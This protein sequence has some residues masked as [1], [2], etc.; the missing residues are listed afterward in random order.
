MNKMPYSIEAEESL[1]GAMLQ[2]S[3]FVIPIATSKIN[4]KDFYSERNRLLYESIIDMQNRV[5]K[6][7][8][9]NPES[10]LRYLKENGLF[11]KLFQNDEAYLMRIIDGTPFYRNAKYYAEIIAEKSL[12]RDL[13][14]A[15]QDI[16]KSAYESKEAETKEVADFAEKKIFEVT[17]RRLDND[18][19]HIRDL[20]YEALTSIEERK[21]HKSAVTGVPSGFTGLDKVTHGFQPS[22]LII[23]AARPSVGKTS[24]ALNIVE[25]VMTNVETM[26]FGIGFFSLEMSRM[27]LVERLISSKARINLSRVRSGDL[28]RTEWT[29]LGQT[30]NSLSQS[31]LLIDDSS[32]LTI[33]EIRGKAR[34]MKYKFAEMSKTSGKNIDLKLIVVDYL[35]LIHSN[36]Q[37]RR[38]GTREQEIADI[39]RGLKAL[40]KELNIPVVAL[41]QLSR[42]VEQRQDKPRLSDLRES[43]SIEQDA[44]LVMFLH[45]QKPNRDDEEVIDERN[46]QVE[47][48]LAKHRNGSII[49]GLPLNF[50]AEQTRFENIYSN[51]DNN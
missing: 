36:I 39:S 12:L 45:R 30:F 11:E 16:Q 40:A 19:I 28:E 18:F 23:L 15:A 10:A 22:D 33:M 41:A 14:L 3:E 20:L 44:D 49:D 37:T 13:I 47:V 42:A 5:E 35:Q 51:T 24:F 7:G 46:N 6:I 2:N 4:S 27:Q 1:L 9:I 32:Q 31:N 29:K 50:V 8:D 34:Q 43:G 17:Q 25:H 48:I 21:K 38:N 26:S